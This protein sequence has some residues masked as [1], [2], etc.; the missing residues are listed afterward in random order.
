MRRLLWASQALDLLT[1]WTDKA[2]VATFGTP[3]DVTLDELVIEAFL[4]ADRRTAEDPV[5]PFKSTVQRL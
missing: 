3:V 1:L 4:P 5:E 2:T